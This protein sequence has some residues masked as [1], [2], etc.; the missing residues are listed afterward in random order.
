MTKY[1]DDT[2]NVSASIRQLQEDIA[3]HRT[4]ISQLRQKTDFQNQEFHQ[5]LRQEIETELERHLPNWLGRIHPNFNALLSALDGVDGLDARDLVSL[6]TK[7]D[8][9]SDAKLD[10]MMQ[11][12]K[13]AMND[14]IRDQVISVLRHSSFPSF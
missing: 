9:V 7:G 4:A 11:N 12:I 8:D 5:F 6:F 10:S 14:A 2:Q 3:A 1:N 13:T